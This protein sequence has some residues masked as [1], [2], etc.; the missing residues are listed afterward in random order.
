MWT[1]HAKIVK[2]LCKPPS[3]LQGTLAYTERKYSN[4]FTV[5]G[6]ACATLS[7]TI[8]GSIFGNMTAQR[9]ILSYFMYAMAIFFVWKRTYTL[10][11]AIAYFSVFSMLISSWNSPY[12]LEAYFAPYTGLIM[13]L[14]LGS[15]KKSLL[16]YSIFT[17]VISW[18]L[19]KPKIEDSIRSASNEEIILAVQSCFAAMLRV[20]FSMCCQTCA[21]ILIQER[22]TAEWT[23]LKRRIADQNEQLR[24]SSE[25][26]NKALEEKETFILS[27]S[28]ETRNPLNGLLGNLQTLSEM[29][30]SP[31]AKLVVTKALVCSTI[32]KNILLTILDSRKLGQGLEGLS[33]APSPTD[34]KKFIEEN[35]MLCKDLIRAKGLTPVIDISPG[36]PRSL[37]IDPERISQVIFNLVTNAIKFTEQGSIKVS[38]SW[39]PEQTTTENLVFLTAWGLKEEKTEEEEELYN[40]KWF[41]SSYRD[42]N[43]VLM[44]RVQDTG[45]GIKKDHQTMIFEKFSH[46]NSSKQLKKLGLGLGLWVSKMIV[47]SH[48][49]EILLDSQEGK[50]SCFTAM[51]PAASSYSELIDEI[52]LSESPGKKSKTRALVV[53]DFP[54]NQ[55]INAEML[56]KYGIGEVVIAQNGLEAV[57]IFQEKG[58]N[59]FDVITMDLEMPVMKG[60]DAIAEIRRLENLSKAPGSKIV[61]ISGN[62]IEKEMQECTDPTGNIRAEAFLTKPCDYYTLAKTLKELGVGTLKPCSE[63]GFN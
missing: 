37:C 56:K 47:N 28:H 61:I 41:K 42:E 22:I 8:V 55:T 40:S 48:K 19:I 13:I 21:R 60:K 20:F 35:C 11:R 6:L 63:G 58:F 45:C 52:D 54:I 7:S 49:G 51:I 34:M 59:Y 3:S 39:L 12:C 62:A 23:T 25:E 14:T 2:P 1:L 27:F 43:G 50:G 53:E 24:K 33:L 30:L 10:V 16:V 9:I 18:Y 17:L 36:F 29:P 46:V 4:Y 32:L 38:F 26:L 44:I 57:K 15:S 31:Q 5:Y